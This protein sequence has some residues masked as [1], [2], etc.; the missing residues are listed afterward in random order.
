MKV[1]RR[2]VMMVKV[3]WAFL[4]IL[5]A[6]PVG[7]YVLRPRVA[8]RVDNDVQGIK[9]EH[10]VSPLVTLAV[11]LSAFVAAQ[12]TSSYRSATEQAGNEAGAVDQFFETAGL[13]PGPEGRSIQASTVCYARA[14][15]RLEWPSMEH[16]TTADAVGHW[17]DEIRAELPAI[18]DGPSPVVSSMLTLDRQRS[19]ARR[20]RLTEMVPSIPVPVLML[21]FLAVLGVVL[22]LATLALP[23]IRR[24]NLVA[25]VGVIALLLG[26][27]LY[28]VEQLEE[29]YSG[30][31]RI[32]PVAMERTADS[33]AEDY[34]AAHTAGLPCD[35]DGAPLTT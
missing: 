34:A 24:R 14:V 4:V 19:E 33:A 5:V 7:L 15:H 22:A 17:T 6:V 12:A 3:I 21:M 35:A 28:L 18:V 10:I 31:M 11:F 30:I 26:G 25:I 2:S 23:A 32:S 16:G 9:T 27:T 8:A 1:E 20:L 29:P 13:L